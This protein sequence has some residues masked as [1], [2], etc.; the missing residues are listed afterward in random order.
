TL[1][2]VGARADAKKLIEGGYEAEPDAKRKHAMARARAGLADEGEDRLLWLNRGNTDDPSV[3][4]KPRHTRGQ[5]ALE[6]SD[7]ARAAP[8]AI[9]IYESMPEWPASLNNA[10]ICYL[11]LHRASGE[12]DALKK[13]IAKLEKALSLRP[14][15]TILLQNTADE[16][17]HHAVREA[18]AGK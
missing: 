14:E 8:Q 2:Q 18:L 7:A 10:A 5:Q 4:A 16:V 3:P 12:E 1:R 9:A 11:G 6:K 13:A 15:D 17:W